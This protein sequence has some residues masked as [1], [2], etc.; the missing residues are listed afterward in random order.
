MS[1]VLS[2]NKAGN[3]AQ[4]DSTT[5]NAESL[6]QTPIDG[7]QQIILVESTSSGGILARD[8]TDA[9][10]L[11]YFP[12]ALF[13]KPRNTR[14]EFVNRIWQDLLPYPLHLDLKTPPF[15]E[16]WKVVECGL[17]RLVIVPDEL[18][19][20]ASFFNEFWGL[21]TSYCAESVVSKL[22]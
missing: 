2:S 6:N 22:K 15:W 8:C 18:L 11:G 20:C 21:K 14:G 16:S 9:V 19:P 10:R 5:Q 4:D 3:E 7:L 1:V 13:N 17:L 12:L